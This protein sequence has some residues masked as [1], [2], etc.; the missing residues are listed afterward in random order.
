MG[1]CNKNWDN[2]CDN[3]EDITDNPEINELKKKMRK[4]ARY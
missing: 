1:K 4:S 2:K 3:D